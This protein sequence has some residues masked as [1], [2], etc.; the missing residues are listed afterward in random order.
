M[1]SRTTREFK[2]QSTHVTAMKIIEA[3]QK[4]RQLKTDRL[5][6]LRL[7]SQVKVEEDHVSQKAE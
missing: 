3:E 2:A 5:R 1:V 6:K 7:A 4:Q